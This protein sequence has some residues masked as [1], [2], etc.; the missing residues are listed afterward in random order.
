MSFSGLDIK[1]IILCRDR[2]VNEDSVDDNKSPVAWIPIPASLVAGAR[3]T[4]VAYHGVVDALS[5]NH[6]LSPS[7]A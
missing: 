2:K 6:A 5:L 4:R 7:S 1:S 3:L